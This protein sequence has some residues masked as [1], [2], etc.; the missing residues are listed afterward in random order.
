MAHTKKNQKRKEVEKSIKEENRQIRILRFE[1][2]E[3]CSLS[4][5]EGEI[6]ESRSPSSGI[7]SGISMP[8]S[9]DPVDQ[10]KHIK[11]TPFGKFDLVTRA[12]IGG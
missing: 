6:L 12:F 8:D 9:T 4:G 3:R 2:S 1:R 7:I 10:N 5:V 11:T